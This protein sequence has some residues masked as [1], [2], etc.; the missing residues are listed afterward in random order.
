M[1]NGQLV[2]GAVR[3]QCLLI[4]FAVFYALFVAPQ[5]NYNSNIKDHWSQITTANRI[6]MKKSEM[7]REISKCNAETQRQAN[8]VGINDK[9]RLI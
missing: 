5:N 6:I 7:L 9:E 1:E 3:I 8:A 4:M 2:G